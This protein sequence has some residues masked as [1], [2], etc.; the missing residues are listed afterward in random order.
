MWNY[1]EGQKEFIIPEKYNIYNKYNKNYQA[2]TAISK[3]LNG[4]HIETNWFEL[5]NITLHLL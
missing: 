1:R 2:D 4:R 5:V 3:I